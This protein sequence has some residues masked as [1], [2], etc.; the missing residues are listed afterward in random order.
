MKLSIITVNYNNCKGLERTAKSVVEQISN[1][2]EWIV[3]DGGSADGSVDIIRQYSDNIAYWISEPDNGIYHAM[4]KGIDQANGDYCLFLNS[5]DCF[6]SP[7]SLIRAFSKN[8][9]ADIVTFDVFISYGKK[10]HV[11]R[12]APQSVPYQRLVSGTINHQSTFIRTFLLKKNKY[13]ED[14][15]IASDWIFWIECLLINNYSYQ[16]IN[17]PISVFDTTGI[18]C[19][20]FTRTR[21]ERISY[22]SSLFSVNIVHSVIEQTDLFNAFEAIESQRLERQLMYW[23]SRVARAIYRR[24]IGKIFEIYVNV[25]FR[26]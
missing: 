6:A 9:T 21:D 8:P 19:T 18:S 14:Y 23:S 11:Y 16:G 13:H 12:A 5:G 15:K 4:N 25:K 17:I 2:Y 26:A 24:T 1:N 7:K 20:N 3:I 10:L 22:L